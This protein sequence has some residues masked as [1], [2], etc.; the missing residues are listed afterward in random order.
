MPLS[1]GGSRL[2]DLTVTFADG[3]S[4]HNNVDFKPRPRPACGVGSV[5]RPNY[6]LA[7][8]IRGVPP[9][10]DA[11]A[12]LRYETR[13]ANVGTQASPR[14]LLNFEF[15]DTSDDY[16]FFPIERVTVPPLLPGES[17]TFVG[18]ASDNA[19][20]QAEDLRSFAIPVFFVGSEGVATLKA[21]V[22]AYDQDHTN[23]VASKR[24][25]I[26]VGSVRTV[27]RCASTGAAAA[28]NGCTLPARKPPILRG[29]A[30]GKV[31]RVQVAVVRRSPEVTPAGSGCQWL[32]NR[33][34]KF[35]QVAATDGQ[36]LDG[37]WLDAEGKRS[38]ELELASRLPAGD[39]VVYSRGIMPSGGIE[40][41]GRSP[42]DNR[43]EMTLR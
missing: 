3:T 24:T 5:P 11:G 8:S 28:G 12:S 17:R 20:R 43:L 13:V 41:S 31:R 15:Q 42:R 30:S 32:S 1:G 37:I 25:E 14:R 4:Y 36:C 34:G 16:D 18:T 38:W 6:D 39:Y 7:V 23:N 35:R 27:P 40:A 29:T 2:T 9:K 19:V 22:P 33:R 10:A 26:S 21:S